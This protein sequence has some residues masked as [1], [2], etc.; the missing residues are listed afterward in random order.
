MSNRLD[1][2]R[3]RELEPLRINVGKQKLLELGIE[4]TFED[5]TSL[6]FVHKGKT[7]RFFP[8]SGYFSG[9]SVKSGRGIQNLLKQ[10]KTN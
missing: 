10:L 1:K 9:Q 5:K 6:H 3:Q 8:Y 2:D 4:V 7:V